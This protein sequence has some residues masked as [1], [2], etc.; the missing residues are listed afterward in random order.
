VLGAVLGLFIG[1]GVVIPLLPTPPKV[2]RQ[3]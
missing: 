1:F 3:S 2:I